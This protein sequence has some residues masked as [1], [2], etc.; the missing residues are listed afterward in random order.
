M[1]TARRCLTISCIHRI[2][3]KMKHDDYDC[4]SSPSPS[5][6]LD[7]DTDMITHITV[8]DFSAVGICSTSATSYAMTCFECG[9]RLTMIFL[10]GNCFCRR[11][12]K[13]MMAQ[14]LIQT[15]SETLPLSLR[16]FIQ[17]Q[18]S[19]DIEYDESTEE[20]ESHVDTVFSPK[21]LTD[22]LCRIFL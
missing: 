9:D 7:T 20:T 19:S 1:S 18:C 21:R 14:R 8:Q 22:S 11:I 12:N 2:H 17:K 13:P 4:H 3:E 5:T 6:S 10:D 15:L 16:P